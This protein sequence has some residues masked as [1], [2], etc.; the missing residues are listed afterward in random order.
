MLRRELRDM[1]R[2]IWLEIPSP[3]I[4]YIDS[5]LIIYKYVI[6]IVTKSDIVYAAAI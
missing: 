2:V 5:I 6:L 3:Y 1:R 4:N